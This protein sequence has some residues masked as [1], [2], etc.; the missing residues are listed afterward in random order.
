MYR[1]IA[2]AKRLRFD[3]GC[4]PSTMNCMVFGVTVMSPKERIV[5]PDTDEQRIDTKG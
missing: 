1:N 4:A 3:E 5:A 2:H